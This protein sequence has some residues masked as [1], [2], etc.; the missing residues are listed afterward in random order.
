MFVE[1][2]HAWIVRR[3]GT[4][5]LETIEQNSLRFR[6]PLSWL[7]FQHMRTTGQSIHILPFGASNHTGQSG[8]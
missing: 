4:G 7:T 3:F 5:G 2:E 1:R 8:H 6:F